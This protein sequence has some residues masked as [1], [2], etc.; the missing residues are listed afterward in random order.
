M[1]VTLDD[2]VMVTVTSHEVTKKGVEGSGKIMSY[3]IYH[4]Y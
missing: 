2:M 4:I 3:N 1:S